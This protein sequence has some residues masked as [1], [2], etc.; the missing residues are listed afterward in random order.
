MIGG[1]FSTPGSQLQLL[2]SANGTDATAGATTVDSFVVPALTAK[3]I[4][5]VIYGMESVTQQTADALLYDVTNAASLI[6]L[7][8]SGAITAGGSIDGYAQIQQRQGNAS[9]TYILAQGLN[10]AAARKDQL[11]FAALGTP[12]TTGGWTMGLRHGGVTA[13]GTYKY[14][15][16]VYVL[17]GQ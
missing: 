17:R 7:A 15:W 16:S 9:S 5:F 8:A 6:S 1:A 11:T 4:L 10:Q 12:W 2:H 13:G 14:N 3:D